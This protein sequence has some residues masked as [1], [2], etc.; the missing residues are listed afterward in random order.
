MR[1]KRV[2]VVLE[3]GGTVKALRPSFQLLEKEHGSELRFVASDVALTDL[4]GAGVDCLTVEADPASVISEF[5][6]QVVLV[7]GSAFERT[8]P[9]WTGL[10]LKYGLAAMD[11][12]IP[13]ILYRDYSGIPQWARELTNHARSNGLLY[14]F[15]FDKMTAHVVSD[16]SSREVRVVGSGSY[17]NLRGFD[18]GAAR[19]QARAAVGLATDDFVVFLNCGAEKRRNLEILEPAVSGLVRLSDPRVVFVPSFHPKD[20]DAPLFSEPGKLAVVRPSVAYDP[21]LANLDGTPVRVVREPLF[22]N[23]VKNPQDRLAASDLVIMFSP[24]ACAARAILIKLI[25]QALS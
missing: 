19:E 9:K 3:M 16:W 6:P 13:V 17:D 2:L 23:A 8:H 5:N 25:F 12:N 24:T 22:R 15:M 4:R 1:D 14:L 7:G 18:W 21:A 20:P 10:E 11:A